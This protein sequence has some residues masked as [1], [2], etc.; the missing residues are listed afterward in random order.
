MSLSLSSPEHVADIAA[1]IERGIAALAST[2]KAAEPPVLGE[3]V[4]DAARVAELRRLGA[5][6]ANYRVAGLERDQLWEVIEDPANGAAVRAN[7]AA[8]LSGRLD[9]A[10][11]RRLRFAASVTAS[12]KVRVALEMSASNATDEQLADALANIEPDGSHE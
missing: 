9:E 6:D 1:R 10:D 11:R 7:A 5:G 2:P 8:A 3:R 12:P 4:T